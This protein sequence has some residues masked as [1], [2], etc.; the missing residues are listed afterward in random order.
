MIKLKVPKNSRYMDN[1]SEGKNKKNYKAKINNKKI[2]QI[3]IKIIRTK[4]GIKN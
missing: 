2:K 3:T 1:P 4:S